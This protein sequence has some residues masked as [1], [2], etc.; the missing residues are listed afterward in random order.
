MI[1]RLRITFD[2]RPGEW[3]E[4]LPAVPKLNPL[5]AL[6]A[7]SYVRPHA[8]A[9]ALGKY[10]EDD[11]ERML[12]NA[13]ATGAMIACQVEGSASW[14]PPEW[15]RYLLDDRA[16]FA[17]IRQVAECERATVPSAPLRDGD[18]AVDLATLGGLLDADRELGQ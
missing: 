5:Y 4:V 13:Y 8:L 10:S 16:R 1:R 17:A 3:V 18:E 12:A 9:I 14:K 6:A 7:Q 11:Q 15:V 2:D